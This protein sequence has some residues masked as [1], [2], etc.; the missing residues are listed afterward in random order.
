MKI[1]LPLLLLILL[2]SPVL[3]QHQEVPFAH[4]VAAFRKQD[5][6]SFP[7]KNQILLIGSSSFT[8]WKDVQDYFPGYPILNRAFG[9][10]TLVDVIRHVKEVV[11]PYNPRQILVYC[12]EN[13]VASSDTVTGEM[14]VA[15]FEKLF[16]LIRAKYPKVPIY[17][18]S[19]KPSPSRVLFRDKV[20]AGNA[21]IRKFLAGKKRT[22]Y[23][24]VYPEMIDDEGK[25]RQELFL[26]DNLHMN[27]EGYKIWQRVIQ[28]Y[29]KK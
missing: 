9:G 24:D 28:P 22:G 23:I 5:S 1:V 29:L 21:G 11:Y 13:D 14:V 8:I 18:V 10:S 27:K 3:A 2:A 4:D 26:D 17:Y 12:G 15:R 25:P 19:M 16:T 7:A 6:A 20:M